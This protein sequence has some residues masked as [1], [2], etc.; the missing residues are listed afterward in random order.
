MFCLAPEGMGLLL[1]GDAADIVWTTLTAAIA[2]A[3]FAAAFGGWIM[4]SANLSERVVAAA[5]GFAL[6]YADARADVA[7]LL[8]AAAAVGAHIVRIRKRPAP[9]T[10][11]DE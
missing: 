6:L 5:A 9:A 4:A 2:V 11:E 10:D 7:G 1:K 3:A 8:L